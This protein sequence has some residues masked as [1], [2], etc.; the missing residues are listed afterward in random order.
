[1]DFRIPLAGSYNTRISTTNALTG[2]S[3][4]VVGVG[5]VGVMIV[6]L[7]GSSTNK[8]QRFINCFTE[9]VLNPYTNQTTL[10][11]VKR[12]GF[13]SALTPQAGSVGN[14]IMIWTGSSSKIISAF[15]ATNSSIYDSSTRLVTNNGTNT[16]ITGLAR[17]I[18]ETVVGSTATLTIASTDSTAWY[19]QPAG[20]VTKITDGDYPGNASLNTVGGFVHMDGYAGIMTSDGRFWHSDLGSVTAWTVTSVMSANSYPDAGIGAVRKGDKIML[21]GTESVQFVY[22]AGNASGSVFSRIEPMT[23]KVGA[24]SADAITSVGDSVF[25]VGSSP[26]GGVSVYEYGSS[27]KRVSTPEIDAVLLLA[28]VANISLTSTKFYGRAFLIVV[29]STTTFVYCVD[30]P[31]WH[32]WYSQVQLWHKCAGVS[33]GSAQP[34]YA[35]SKTSTSG[36]VF[37]INPASLTFQDN[38]VTVTATAQTSR[39]G[40]GNKRTF[41][42]QIEVLGDQESASSP[43]AISVYDD[44]YQTPILLGTVDLMDEHPRI[45]G[46]GASYRRSFVLTNAANAPMRIEALIGRKTVGAS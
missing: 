20:T 45:F 43:T 7:T 35:I 12:P 41:W 33:A 2:P 37:T 23:I 40:D 44:D 39:L 21:F 14:A 36:K 11:L 16:I 8:D 25:W 3:S 19:Y 1:M 42:H 34:I 18:T 22:N 9:R 30:D 17:S 4:G 31:G 28:G 26:E 32:E 6:G 15:G 27:F 24:T 46:C 10:Y 5:V 13:G 38:G 29:A